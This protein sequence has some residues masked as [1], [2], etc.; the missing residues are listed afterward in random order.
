MVDPNAYL[1]LAAGAIL[2]AL[3]LMAGRQRA[4][5]EILIEAPA[6]IVWEQWVVA[7]G[8]NDWR[9]LV[10]IGSVEKLADSPLTIKVKAT[11]KGL[12]GMPVENVWR[13]DVYEPYRRYQCKV[14]SGAGKAE[15]SG[16][17]TELGDTRR[18]P[19]RDG[20]PVGFDLA[21]RRRSW[22]GKTAG[23]MPIRDDGC[24]RGRFIPRALIAR[25]GRKIPRNRNK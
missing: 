14:V 17:L 12:V 1:A 8:N 16:E 10:A 23:K 3:Y 5:F 22:R 13:Y 24:F 19:G 11:A 25:G 21:K 15:E 9:P 2:I 6:R 7:C 20:L 4:G 18:W